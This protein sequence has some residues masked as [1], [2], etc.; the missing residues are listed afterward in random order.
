MTN[1]VDMSLTLRSA[2]SAFQDG[3]AGAE[4]ARILRALAE[5]IDRGAE[6][7]T[8]LHDVNGN[9]IGRATLEIWAEEDA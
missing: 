9:K 2:G 4:I 5:A 7:Y 6:G 8:T 3:N 1:T